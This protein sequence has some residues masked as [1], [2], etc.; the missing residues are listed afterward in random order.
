ME[1]SK[2]KWKLLYHEQIKLGTCY[3]YLCGKP[4]K[5]V[6]EFSLDHQM[7]LSRG[8]QNEASNWRPTHKVCNADKG[9][10]TYEEWELYQELLR[11]KYGHVK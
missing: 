8:G 7:P 10:L 4:I 6:K 9:A 11:K 1:T 3:C 2:K 5:S